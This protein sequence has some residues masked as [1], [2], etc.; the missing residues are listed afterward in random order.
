M[1]RQLTIR[2]KQQYRVLDA[3]ETFNVYIDGQIAAINMGERRPLSWKV[4]DGPHLVEFQAA[5]KKYSPEPVTIP[6]GTEN[7]TVYM[8]YESKGMFKRGIWHTKVLVGE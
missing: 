1:A 6:A 4:S 7:V 2:R 8:E 5:L 3:G